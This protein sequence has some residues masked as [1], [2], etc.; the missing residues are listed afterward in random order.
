MAASI[1]WVAQPGDGGTVGEILARAGA[2]ASAVA[3]GRVFLGRQR[4]RRDDEVVSA[5][6]VVEIARPRDAPPTLSIIG[7]AADLVAVDKPA[8]MP[9][10][11]DQTGAS[12][13]L[14]HLAALTLGL[15]EPRVHATSR[16]D[17]DV[18]GVVVLALT[19]TA[20]ARL[21]DARARGAYERRYLAMAN[22]APGADHGTWNAPIGRAPDPRLRQVSGRDAVRAETHFRVCARAP[23]GTALLAAS[24]VTGRTHQIRVHAA[25]AGAALLGDRAYGGATRITVSGGRVVELRRIALHAA[26]VVV[27]DER[28]ASL[29]FEAPIPADLR[30]VWAALGGGSSVWELALSCETGEAGR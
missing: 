21:V 8:G 24:P 10:I 25:H 29:A 30:E 5:G 27:P 22:R 28:G 17:R 14:V 7:R 12:H 19:R 23:G 9:T 4:V 6:D 2:D 26:R 11:A 20:A 18:S 3:E 1:R 16:L 15:P 13:A